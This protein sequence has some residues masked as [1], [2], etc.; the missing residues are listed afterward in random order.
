MTQLAIQCFYRWKFLVS[1]IHFPWLSQPFGLRLSKESCCPNS[2]CCQLPH[3]L[4]FSFSFFL[5]GNTKGSFL[6]SLCFNKLHSFFGIIIYFLDLRAWYN[7]SESNSH[8]EM[9]SSWVMGK[10]RV[11]L[12]DLFRI[13]FFRIILLCGYCLM[14]IAYSPKND[15]E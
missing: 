9:T 4:S 13:F 11:K 1:P 12:Y 5:F 3:S 15:R 2:T 14:A 8:S 7:M 10:F 6:H